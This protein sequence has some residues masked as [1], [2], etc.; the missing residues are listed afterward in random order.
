MLTTGDAH[1]PTAV[2][3]AIMQGHSNCVLRPGMNYARKRPIG[4]YQEKGAMFEH[5]VRGE[6]STSCNCAAIAA[7]AMVYA[8]ADAPDTENR[9]MELNAHEMAANAM[10]LRDAPVNFIIAPKKSNPISAAIATSFC[11]GGGGKAALR[12]EEGGAYS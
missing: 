10:L 5:L 8:A 9:I 1:A 6:R 3:P 11:C 4:Q 2:P 12:A 7:Q